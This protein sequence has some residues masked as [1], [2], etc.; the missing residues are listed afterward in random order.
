MV[1]GDQISFSQ[2]S[3]NVLLDRTISNITPEENSAF[4]DDNSNFNIGLQ[5]TNAD[6]DNDINES[7]GIVLEKD[8]GKFKD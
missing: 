8:A 3:L 5:Y 1:G 2:K 7:F 6:A 4:V